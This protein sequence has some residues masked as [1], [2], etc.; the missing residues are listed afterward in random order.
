[1]QNPLDNIEVVRFLAQLKESDQAAFMKM[2]LLILKTF[3]AEAL[4]QVSAPETKMEALDTMLNYFQ[5]LEEFEECQ[6]ILELK[7]EISGEAL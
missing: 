1:M 7:K 2:V 5:E 3:R 4:E 6:F